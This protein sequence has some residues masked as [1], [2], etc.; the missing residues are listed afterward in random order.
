MTTAF[1]VEQ[2]QQHS[3][4]G[5]TSPGFGT[6][7]PA[8]AKRADIFTPAYAHP[9]HQPQR[10]ITAKNIY[11]RRLEMEPNKEEKPIEKEVVLKSHQEKN[12]LHSVDSVSENN[13][14]TEKTKKPSNTDK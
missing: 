3:Y 1:Q 12:C 7:D 5:K 9:M 13:K 2:S 4:F 10:M 6:P 14:L 11:S 8:S